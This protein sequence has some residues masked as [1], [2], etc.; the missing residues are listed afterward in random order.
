MVIIVDSKFYIKHWISQSDIKEVFDPL[1]NNT[2]NTFLKMGD[3]LKDAYA[4]SI[5]A[6]LFLFINI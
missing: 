2:P 6:T 1:K 4:K 5:I 3:S